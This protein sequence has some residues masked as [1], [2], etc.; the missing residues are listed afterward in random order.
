M[1]NYDGQNGTF[2]SRMPHAEKSPYQKLSKNLLR[3]MKTIPLCHKI[4][5]QLAKK[6]GNYSPG[7]PTVTKF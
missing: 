1:E 4:V 7:Y 6:K 5:M 2:K 3:P